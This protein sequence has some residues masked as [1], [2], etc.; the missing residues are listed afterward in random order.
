MR[1]GFDL[2][3]A[4]KRATGVGRYLRGLLPALA[5]EGVDVVGLA[6]SWR[7]RVRRADFPGLRIVDRRLPVRLLDLLWNRFAWPPFARLAGAVDVSHSPTPLPLPGAGV[8]RVV[9]VHDLF[10]VR[11][12]DAVDADTA[13]WI[14]RLRAA[15]AAA[16][17]IICVSAATAGAVTE[18]LQVPAERLS[19]VPHGLEPACPYNFSYGHPTYHVNLI[20]LK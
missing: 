17:G 12:P 1:V 5:A 15:L 8:A 4:V 11:Q 18:L 10:F 2:R 9:T 13:A 7:D 3:P 14:A 20:K 16:D 19:V 6:A